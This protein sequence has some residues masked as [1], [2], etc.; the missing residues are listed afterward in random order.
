MTQPITGVGATPQSAQSAPT[1]SGPNIPAMASQIL[2]DA[3][4]GT[5]RGSDHRSLSHNLN[6]IEVALDN[7][8]MRDPALANAVRSEV[9]SQLNAVEA[10]QLA[11]L[12]PGRTIS[13]GGREYIT[14]ADQNG[15]SQAEWITQ[16]RQNDTAKYQELVRLAGS[17]DD[18]AIGRV[19]DKLYQTGMTPEQLGTAQLNEASLASSETLQDLGQMALD[20]VGIFDPTPAADLVNAGWSAWRG[21]GW[22]AFLSV[23]SAVPY[24][25][26]AA[27]LGKLGKW[28]ETTAKAIEMAANNPAMKAMLEP[29]LKK[30]SDLI[31]ALPA[32]ALDS[33]PASAKA[34]LLAMKSKIDDLL[35]I[36]GRKADDVAAAAANIVQRTFG[37][38]A[39]QWTRDAEGRLVSASAVLK[40]VFPGLTRSADEVAAQ[41]R[42]A[43][44]GID[45]DHGGHAIPHRF[46]GDQGDINM[47]PQ[48]GVPVGAAK[49]FNG[50]AFKTLENELADWVQAGA[51]VKYDINFSDFVGDRPGTVAIEYK[52]FDNAGNEV[53]RNGDVFD[54]AAG[55]VF[56][57]MS[58]S[59]I[60][61]V[62]NGAG[63]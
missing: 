18:A 62:L 13:L 22:G 57:R 15:I 46:I 33:L 31:G 37:Q 32:A 52:V 44:K 36:A 45:G 34:E 26:D 14:Y 38:N 56:S 24:I 40:E 58:R 23:V 7:I 10:G 51:T 48:N 47:F 5:R 8:K 2:N 21:D 60:E 12:E 55:Q 59:E 42:A 41:G 4:I 54:N 63:K 1:G 3:T 19:M 27:K 50:S 17:N 25:G 6:A 9:Q 16:N 43:A 30:I 61:A 28:A 49:N 20:I 35:G 29:S 39:V 11:R 53:F